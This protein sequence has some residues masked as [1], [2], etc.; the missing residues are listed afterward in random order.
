ML[1][2]CTALLM[3]TGMA[4]QAAATTLNITL[5]GTPGPLLSGSDPLNI[6]GQTVGLTVA[7]N[8]S[9]TPTTQASNYVSYS[10]P[11][12]AVSVTVIGIKFNNTQN[13]TLEVKLTRKADILTVIAPVPLGA[14]ITVT[15][16]LAPG[17]WNTAVFQHPTTFSPSPQNLTPAAVA[18]QAGSQVKYIILGSR[19]I[20][21]LTGTV[22]N[23]AQ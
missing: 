3:G 15:A 9:L 13:A 8:E 4:G 2:F 5:S 20:L 23:S 14:I 17:S 18:N 22:D 10:L 19:S 7:A 11:P 12:G 1:L 21:G 16:F 6:Q